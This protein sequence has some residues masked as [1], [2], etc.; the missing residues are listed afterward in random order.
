MAVNLKVTFANVQS[1]HYLVLYF[2]SLGQYTT[3]SR[4]SSDNQ[5]HSVSTSTYSVIT[6]LVNLIHCVIFFIL[7]LI[8]EQIKIRYVHGYVKLKQ[9]PWVSY[10]TA[11]EGYRWRMSEKTFVIANVICSL[12]YKCCKLGY[13]LSNSKTGETVKV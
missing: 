6:H 11:R 3:Y 9:C 4:P 13:N 2:L 1:T 12:A 8:G 10:I 7:H 5:G